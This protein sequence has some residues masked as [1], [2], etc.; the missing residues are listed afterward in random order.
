MGIGIK[1]G[2][3]VPAVLVPNRFID[4]YMTAA[5]GEY[6]KVYLYLLRHESELLALSVSDIA[7]A[8]NHTEAD[9]KRAIAYWKKAG[10]LSEESEKE[11]KMQS[12]ATRECAEPETKAEAAAF[13]QKDGYERLKRLAEDD[14]FS[15]LLYA[16]QQYL[17]KTFTQIE[18]EKFAF[19]YDGLH[20]T[21]EL[22]EYLAEYCAGGGHTSIRYIEKV[23]LNWY[24]LGI[25]TKEEAREYTL[26][27]SKDVSSVMKAFGITGRS[28][29][30]TEQAYM[31]KWFKEYGFDYKLVTEAC[32]RTIKA[33]GMASFPYADKILAG[34]KE[35]GVKVLRDVDE[36]DK[37]RQSEKQQT[38]ERPAAKKASAPNRFKNFDE[39][40]NQY[41]ELVFENIRR[42]Q[43]KE[44]AEGGTQ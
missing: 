30:A 41:E 4:T 3:S 34:W 29:A 2:L 10:V 39:R 1:D 16:V 26:R 17:G 35:K 24:Q 6:V 37:K 33:T 43:Q 40:T 27:Y 42:R 9:V 12:A 23:A 36:L 11:A 15:A 13:S 14:E 18:C 32:N 44:A 21:C 22:L 5:N 7:D 8:L 25:R 31:K 19:F 20:M 28:P 38:K